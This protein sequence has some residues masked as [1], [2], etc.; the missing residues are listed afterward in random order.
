MMESFGKFLMLTAIRHLMFFQY[1]VLQVAQN[2][3]C[4]TVQQL[5]CKYLFIAD[6]KVQF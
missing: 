4:S 2:S 5:L 3:Y 6:D 1:H